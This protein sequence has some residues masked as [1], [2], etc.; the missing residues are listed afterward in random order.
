MIYLSIILCQ[1]FIIFESVLKSVLN[2]ITCCN[3]LDGLHLPEV[4][5]YF[6][7]KHYLEIMYRPHTTYPFKV[8]NS[9][10]FNIFIDMYSHQHSQF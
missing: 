8:G 1:M 2:T 4:V 10:D 6:F 3:Q 7:F 5:F 9:V